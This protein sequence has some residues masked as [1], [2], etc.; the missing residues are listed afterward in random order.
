MADRKTRRMTGSDLSKTTATRTAA[1][2]EQLHHECSILLELYTKKETFSSDITVS[3][4]RL[5]SVPPPS[6]QLDTKDNLWRLHSALLQCRSLLDSAIAKEE[7]E[8]GTGRKGEYETQRKMVK[9]RLS[10]LLINVGELL[11]AVDGPG[12]LMPNLDR[13]EGDDS[14]VFELKVWVYRIFKEVE[15]WTKTTITTLNTLPSVITKERV[16]TTRIRSMRSARK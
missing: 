4:G 13:L 11:K 14:T 15:H 9:D 16:R 8:L 2:A 10:L 12:V 6:S 1:I 5:V 3:D 7:V